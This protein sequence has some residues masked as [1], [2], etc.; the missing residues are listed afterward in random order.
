MKR[1]KNSKQMHK[2]Q[3]T[4]EQRREEKVMRL[5]HHILTRTIE[6]ANLVLDEAVEVLTLVA[7]ALVLSNTSDED[8]E[9]RSGMIEWIQGH[10]V[11][12]LDA[13]DPL[14]EI[15]HAWIVPPQGLITEPV[16]IFWSGSFDEDAGE[17]VQVVLGAELELLRSEIA[18]DP[19]SMI[20]I[21]GVEGIAIIDPDW[22]GEDTVTCENPQ[23]GKV[24][25]VH[26][27]VAENL[28]KQ[29]VDR[30]RGLDA[31]N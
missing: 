17:G 4:A 31:P 15:P 28:F 27:T 8:V 22:D 2:P 12:G 29:A 9:D 13:I 19:A 16:G 10:F 18:E 5:A 7:K 26:L 21:D 24:H 20:V 6:P 25:D 23:C 1:K 14:A 30:R 11:T 3:Q